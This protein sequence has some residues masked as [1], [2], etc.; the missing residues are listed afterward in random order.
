MEPTLTVTDVKNYI[1]CPR[2]VYYHYFLPIRPTTFKMEEGKRAW[3]RTEE[4]EERRSLRA[5]NLQDGHREFN[6]NLASQRLGI[7]GKIDMAILRRSE[8]IPVEFKNTESKPGLNHK[9]QLA[10]YGLLCEEAF[11]RPARRGFIYLI[12]AKRPI[13]LHIA[14]EVRRFTTQIIGRIR[15]MLDQEQIPPPTR[16]RGRCRDCEFRRWCWDID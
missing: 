8:V 16:N 4:L 11:H 14:P 7:L 5:Y 3:E 6:V 15:R 1:Y 12:P 2:V 13:E 10:T 9:Y